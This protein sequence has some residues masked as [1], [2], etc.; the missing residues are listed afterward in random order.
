[1]AA[2]GFRDLLKSGGFQAFLWTQFLGALNDNLYKMVVSLRAV[3]VAAG[4]GG[5]TLSLAGVVFVAPF[6]LF[7][8]YS[9]RLADAVSK[10][11]V[12]VAVKAFE[13]VVMLLGLAAFFST[14]IELMLAVL[15][16]MALHSTVFSPAKYGIVP[17]ILGDQD[18]SRA[19]GLL[20]MSTFV[21]IVLGTSIGSFLFVMWKH[22]PANIGVVMIAIAC[23]GLASSF[24]IPRVRAAGSTAPFSLNPFAE[25]VAG[26]KR[27]LGNRPLWLAV[28][29]NSYFWFLGAL[30]QM[31]LLLFGSETLHVD[32]WRVGFMLTAL[33]VGIG[34]GSMLAGR[35]SGDKVELGLVP[36][37]SI[38]M[39][40]A[41][42]LLY[43][44]RGSYPAS[45]AAVA[46]LGLAG[47]LYIVPLNAF[48]QQRAGEHE[49]GRLIA[50]NNFYNTIGLLLASAVL[51]TLHDR[52]HVTP[53][54]L[55]L[56]FAFVTIG[57]TIY[58]VS[59]VPDFLVRFLLWML[60]HTIYKIRIEGQENVP[61]RGPALLVANHTAHVDGFLIGASVQRFIRFMVWRPYY[62]KP[63]FNAVLRLMK[64]IPVGGN[65]RKDIE[66]IRRARR[67]ITEGHTVCIF[68]EG[69]VSRTGNML[70]FKHGFERIVEGLDVPVIPV[71]LDRLWG[72]IFSFER[73]KFFWKLPKRLPYPVTVTFGA[74][75]TSTAQ[76]YEV[77][78]AIQELGSA[79]VERRKTSRD[80]LP[81]RFIR[82]ARRNWTRFAMADST[83][84]ELTFG[85]ALAG[86]VLISDWLAD[87]RRDEKMIGVLLPS[88]VGGALV[89]VGVALAGKTPVNLNYTAGREAM[90][91]ASSHCGLRT[92][93]TSRL[94]VEKLK[95]DVGDRAVFVEDLF[96]LPKARAFLK[97]RLLPARVLARGAQD[98]DA[99]ATVIFSSGSTGVPKGVMLSHYNI[100]ANIEAMAQV[101]SVT[102]SDRLVGVLPF[103][104]SF[105][106]TVT[107]WFPMVTGCG[108]VYHPNPLDAK[109]IG[110]LTARYHATML[111]STPTFCAA[112]VRKCSQEDFA[113]LRLVLTGA[114]KLRDG[115]ANAFEEKFGIR[116][117]EG[118]GATEMAPVISVNTFDYQKQKGNKP[119]TVGHPLPGVAIRI[120]EPD[121]RRPL[122]PNEPGLLLAK[123]CNRMQGYFGQPERTSE[124]IEDGWYVTGDIATMDDDGFLR[125]TDRLSRFSKIAG[126]MVPHVR[127]EEALGEIL[128]DSPCAVTAVPDEQR[129]E[130]LVA[131][132]VSATI[133][134]TEV[135]GRLKQSSLPPL[136]IPKAD[137]IHPVEALPTLGTGKLDLRGLK[138]LALEL[139]RA[140]AS[141]GEGA[142]N[143]LRDHVLR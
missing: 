91:H 106:F 59:V 73:R 125:I 85:R 135:W 16:L 7:S 121:T 108:V 50:T 119:G 81:L 75:L 96:K 124:A 84:R 36:L 95:L 111:L 142:V 114:E 103:F 58:I 101:F 8:G 82:T 89:N 41:S 98:P 72:S 139:S 77:R 68:A 6:L 24:R 52:L 143:Q 78:Q 19:N 126:E 45:M 133:P 102:G 25:V 28:L 35:L 40:V 138:A 61:F 134:P 104:H 42:F 37:G 71:H 105:G 60:T 39:S 13:V 112:Y 69:A 23:I 47:G 53:H 4:G 94:F 1:M 67:E 2:G 70:P 140:E 46:A 29:A 118:Y 115:V 33:A 99:L 20:E 116:P 64:A 123:G 5:A 107:I 14:R 57:A 92:I 86:G 129:G 76:A 15:F 110:E 127:I 137:D 87:N 49:K 27:L 66:S 90:D 93:I 74:P 12:L 18:L 109:P 122:P 136:W 26:T 44:A 65:P 10:R 83:G 80:T 48:L 17:E 11:S 38:G 9:G 51:W 88:T 31:D 128:G 56:I 22:Q 63:G 141:I 132:Y 120:V 113:S 130:R 97:A 34:C 62:E 79:A 3:Q 32:E 100:V 43:V 54:G 131:V 21:A 117:L 30:L 55:V